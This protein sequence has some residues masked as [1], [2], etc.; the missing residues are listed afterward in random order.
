[1]QIGNK[2]FPYPTLNKN[3]DISCFKE[4]KYN[5][6]FTESIENGYFILNDIKINIENEGIKKLILEDYLSIGLIIECKSTIFRK[7]YKLNTETTS[8]KINVQD[9]NN[10]VEISCYIYANKN[11]NNFK[12]DDFL[13]EY[14]N[15]SFNL[16]KNDILAIDDGFTI[17]LDYDIKEDRKVDS[18][19][20]VIKT[21]QIENITFERKPK[22]I[23]I[24]LPEKA[25]ANYIML[26]DNENFNNIF[27][28]ILAIPALTSALKE[29]QNILLNEDIELEDI[30]IENI[31]FLSVKKAYKLVENK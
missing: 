21:S 12:N 27:F 3:N 25:Y 7:I 28:S 15:Y 17:N 22:N 24:N 31:W 14:E 16:R 11:I 5:F 23:I 2:L 6:Q 8:I 18:I 26:K 1:M 9:L 19:F 10:K 20:Q 4:T 13:E 30:E 29:L